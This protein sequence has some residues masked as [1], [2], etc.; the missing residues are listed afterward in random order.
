MRQVLKRLG[1]ITCGSNRGRLALKL[2]IAANS[3]CPP[4]RAYNPRPMRL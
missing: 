3:G 2:R 4:P 1:A